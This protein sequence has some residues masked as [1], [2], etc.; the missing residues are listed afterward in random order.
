M[1]ALFL[2]FL[3]ALLA[4]AFSPCAVE[5]QEVLSRPGSVGVRLED[6]AGGPRVDALVPD[7][8]AARAGVRPGE[9]LLSV[10]GRAAAGRG[11]TVAE[12]LLA[13]PAGTPV[14]VMLAGMDGV[15]RLRLV[16]E[17]VFAP[18]A[19]YTETIAGKYFVVHHRRTGSDRAAA[20]RVARRAERVAER[21]LRGIDT[22][23]RRF[24]AYVVGPEG[25]STISR[26]ARNEL[27]PGWVGW[28]YIGP[29]DDEVSFGVALAYLRF[30]EGGR[31]VAERLGGRHGW[32]IP[33]DPLHRAAVREIMG[34]SLP[35]SPSPAALSRATAGN[36]AVGASLRAY[37]RDRFGDRRFAA[38]W[39]SPLPFDSAAA[40]TLGVSE[41]ELLA[42]WSG[43]VYALGPDPDA[44]PGL[45]SFAVGAGYAA[46]LLLLG[47]VVARRKEV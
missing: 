34:T 13:G 29:I 32:G 27:L 1:P 5:A 28:A 22:G 7:G 6:D 25:I 40:R 35:P 2:S 19:G 4:A 42:D 30:G 10:D 45:G 41:R 14:E 31:R 15:R 24:H 37:L 39:T 36:A 43:K 21:E 3:L 17:D 46:L 23:G 20:R 12:A 8:P 26:R 11:A 38:L 9:R 18:A 47:A 44:G 16:R 33:A